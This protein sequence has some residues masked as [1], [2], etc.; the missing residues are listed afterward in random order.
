MEKTKKSRA[1]RSHIISAK[2][3]NLSTVEIQFANE[4]NPNGKTHMAKPFIS[5]SGEHFQ[6]TSISSV[7]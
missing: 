4:L 3:M 7:H 1:C 6:I 5:E 2:G